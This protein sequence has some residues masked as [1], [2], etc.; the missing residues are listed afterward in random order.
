MC[1]A[2]KR[3]RQGESERDDDGKRAE[4]ISSLCLR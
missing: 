2:M 4:K 3:N 1:V